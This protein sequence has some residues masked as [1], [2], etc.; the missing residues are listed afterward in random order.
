MRV[1]LFTT[2]SIPQ[3]GGIADYLDNLVS[4]TIHLI[5]WS[6]YSTI[7][8]DVSFDKNL[9]YVIHR[10]AETRKHGQRIG[11]GNAIFR[12]INTLCWYLLRPL[13]AA[14][15]IEHAIKSDQPDLVVIGRWC[16]E[17]HYW[18]RALRKKNIKYSLIAHGLELVE[19][20]EAH[21]VTRLIT[22]PGDQDR[23]MDFIL[24]DLVIA[25]SDAT[26]T[27]LCTMGVSL[28]KI[29]KLTPGIYPEKLQPLPGV[30]C[31]SELN[32]L[33]ITGK[34][35]LAMGRLV[36]R[37]GFDLAVEAF[38]DI[39]LEFPEV[40]LV[41]A[42]EGVARGDIEC[43]IRTQNI[44]NR[45][46]LTGE[47][48][49]QQKRALYQ[50]CEFFVMPNRPLPGD[51]EGFGIVFLEANIFNKAVIGGDNGGVPDAVVEG[52]TGLLVQTDHNHIP[53]RDAMRR[54]LTDSDYRDRLGNN[55]HDRAFG[56]FNWKNLGQSFIDT[57]SLINN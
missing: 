18:C 56:H 20:T 46:R 12:R 51:M 25:N 7:P 6:V 54:L 43:S 30:L 24:A 36:Q 3:F 13:I 23:R 34:F 47:V 4:T 15:Q 45:V 14:T 5:D 52:V 27:M 40:N 44:S 1:T 55:G 32:G 42:G 33:G 16:S 41:I 37:K 8:A 26:A 48:T 17:A 22:G 50:S 29:I 9:M 19:P 28:D 2:D 49:M 21:L 31:R 53:L 10:L 39:A 35:I 11:D 57:L 38:A